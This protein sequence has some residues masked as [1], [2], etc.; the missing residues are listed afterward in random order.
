M[1]LTVVGSR[2]G[3]VTE[4]LAEFTEGFAEGFAFH[5]GLESEARLAGRVRCRVR[6][7]WNLEPGG[8]SLLDFQ[9][10][11]LIEIANTRN[12]HHIRL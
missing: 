6:F 8:L 7:W 11:K 9:T 1:L 12:P 10:F 2:P 5:G 3:Y 4:F